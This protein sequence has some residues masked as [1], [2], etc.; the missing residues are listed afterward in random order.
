MATSDIALAQL[1]T[2]I[3]D[4]YLVDEFNGFDNIEARLRDAFFGISP[5]EKNVFLLRLIEIFRQNA[6][7]DAVVPGLPSGEYN[8]LLTM[9]L[10][11]EI[12]KKKLPPDEMIEQLVGAVNTVFDSVNTLVG[13]INATL[14]G[15][16]SGDG[17][18][19][20]RMVIRSSMDADEGLA[21]LKKF[22]DQTGEFFAIALKAYKEA[23]Q[24]KIGEILDELNP[25]RLEAEAG[26]KMKFGP[27]HKAHLYDCYL[28]KYKTLKNWQRSGLLLEAFMKEFE[29]NCQNLYSG[30]HMD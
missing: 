12:L 14:V 26:G 7:G 18:E 27:L 4:A 3:R 23:A 20:I 5:A 19:T 2:E 10:G 13:G 17:E 15:R 16:G 29:K 24:V 21:A 28:D 6:V 22:L 1:A 30:Q 8:K 9:L 25:E 11:K